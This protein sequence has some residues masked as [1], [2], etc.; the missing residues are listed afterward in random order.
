MDVKDVFNL[1]FAIALILS[2]YNEQQT[3]FSSTSPAAPDPPEDEVILLLY[4]NFSKVELSTLLKL[5]LYYISQK[6]CL[7]HRSLYIR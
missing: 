2:V 6:F 7:D 3:I 5:H 1:F 4:L